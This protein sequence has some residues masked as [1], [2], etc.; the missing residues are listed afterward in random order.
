LKKEQKNRGEKKKKRVRLG[1]FIITTS[2]VVLYSLSLLNFD[3]RPPQPPPA[4]TATTSSGLVHLLPN[5]LVDV[6]RKTSIAIVSTDI[7]FRP[8]RVSPIASDFPPSGPDRP[9]AKAQKAIFSLF[10][11]FY[12]VLFAKD[13]N[14]N[15]RSCPCRAALLVCHQ[16]RTSC[17]F[18]QSIDPSSPGSLD[19][20]GIDHLSL[21]LT[22]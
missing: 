7:A 11:L 19:R 17:R 18:P 16:Q 2:V 22:N 13:P 20:L 8:P 10:T 9:L 21:I 6:S 15:D 14:P 5:T 3:H 1:R 4:L 12:S